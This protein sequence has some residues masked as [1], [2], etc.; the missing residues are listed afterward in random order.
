MSDKKP[1]TFLDVETSAPNRP[2]EEGAAEPEEERED[3]DVAVDPARNQLDLIGTLEEG[4]TEVTIYKPNELEVSPQEWQ[5]TPL[6]GHG[7]KFDYKTLH[8]KG[9]LLDVE[10]YEHDTLVMAVAAVTKV[11]DAYLASYE[12]ERRRL[13]EGRPKGKGF[14][15]A[16]K[17]G[18]KILAPYFLGVS[19]FWENPETTN[20]PEYLK[21][22]VLY[23]KGLH[24][25]FIPMLKKEGVWEFYQEKLMPWQ[26]MTLTAELDGICLN[27]E[28]LKDLEQQA[29]A[30][31]VTSLKRLREMWAKVEEEWAYKQKKELAE[32]YALMLGRAQVKCKDSISKKRAAIEAEDK[33]AEKKAK[34][35][36]KLV[37]EE[38]ER[39]QAAAERY[40]KLELAA[41]SK[42]EPF[43]YG[44]SDQLLWAFKNVLH[45]PAVDMEG[46]E[47][48][49]ASV[50]ELL[51]A[52]GKEDIKALLDYKGFA[53]LVS[54]YFPNYRAMAINGRLHCSF[55]LHGART[56]RLSSS[57][58]NLQ[59]VPPALKRLFVAGEGN[60]LV[61]QDLS[62]IEPALI[63][64]FTEDANLCRILMNK[65]DFHGWAA[66]L[67]KLVKCQAHEVKKLEPEVRYGA[68]QGDLSTFYGSGKK[69]LFTTLT[70]NGIKKL[71]DGTP[72]SEQVCARMVYSF[73]DYFHESWE[74]KQMLDAELQA[75][76]SITNLLGRK[77]VIEDPEDVYMK[78]FNRLIQGSASDL[79]LQG[80]YDCLKEL[81]ERGIWC[82]LRL[83]VHDNSVLECA[84]KH[85]EFVNER[86][87]YHLTKFK[88]KT[89]HGLV[90]LMVEGGYA[91]TWK[92]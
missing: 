64:Y 61:S 73:R 41:L 36:E 58:P 19:P 67:F 56:G 25:H 49:G 43:N 13:N 60:V 86:L 42:L 87:C 55:N 48:T 2:T 12:K 35:L 30:G 77:F 69:R 38:P 40:N 37:S 59:Q 66:V 75:G 16:K 80:T 50:L 53:K 91:K 45:Y 54:S 62:A 70:L 8:W 31:L 11:P 82:R 27:F 7:F 23:T 78:G 44:S 47:T 22:D 81:D 17:H 68:K 10:Q 92:G 65:E 26:R 76:N 21:K 72:L 14:R 84:E 32:S 5:C 4:S 52:Q 34:A 33:P 83:L 51:A 85:A 18:L 88:L 89:K 3:D 6:C 63:A 79:L 29:E 9:Y 28:A 90:P 74:F 24:D 71:A 20:D 46:K 57:D 15:P 39:L 1:L